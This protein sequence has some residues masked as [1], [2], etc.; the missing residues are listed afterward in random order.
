MLRCDAE[1]GSGKII[2]Y[3]ISVRAIP[4][5]H[6]CLSMDSELTGGCMFFTINLIVLQ[7]EPFN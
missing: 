4:D 3:D 6:W 1:H 5:Q 2:I 7:Y